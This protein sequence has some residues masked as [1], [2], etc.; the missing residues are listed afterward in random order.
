MS[1]YRTPKAHNE[2][3]Q[4]DPETFEEYGIKVR[5]A[6]CPFNLPDI[7]GWDDAPRSDI[8]TKSWK[9]NRAQQYR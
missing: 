6:R 1:F 8:Q 2:A 5:S 7:G 4:Y 9:D 3:Q